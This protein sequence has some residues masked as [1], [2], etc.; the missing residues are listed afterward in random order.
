M[1]FRVSVA[2]EI[3]TRAP[4]RLEVTQPQIITGYACFLRG[5]QSLDYISHL[6]SFKYQ[7]IDH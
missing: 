7:I 3:G 6:I 5:I 2:P 4:T 1:Y